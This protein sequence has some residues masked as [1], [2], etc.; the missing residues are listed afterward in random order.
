MRGL[1]HK[2]DSFASRVSISSGGEG[3]FG[4]LSVDYCLQWAIF[5]SAHVV[6]LHFSTN[7]SKFLMMQGLAA[8]PD[9]DND[10]GQG[11]L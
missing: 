2:L 10:A 4:Y 3:G 9:H 8:Q 7:S 11:I 1:K 5:G 6:V